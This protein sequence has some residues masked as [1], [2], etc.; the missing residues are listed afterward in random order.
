MPKIRDLIALRLTEAAPVVDA[1]VEFVKVV[2]GLVNQG[3]Y[4]N[5]WLLSRTANGPFPPESFS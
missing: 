4:D 5:S 1:A 3:R 2:D